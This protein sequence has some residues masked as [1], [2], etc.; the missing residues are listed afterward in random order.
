MSE[1]G[2]VA[3]EECRRKGCTGI[4]TEAERRGCSCH[5]NPPCSACT[6]DVAYCS[7]CDWHGKDDQYINDFR[8]SVN[9]ATKMFEAYELR[10]LDPNK[11][12]WHSKSHTHFSMIKEGIYPKGMTQA[13]IEKQV[14]GTFGGK[15]EY[16]NGGKFKYVAYTD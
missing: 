16:F 2:Y 13:E 5:I 1:Y 3:G 7:V 4:I 8:V 9:L 10:K 11:L 12:D 15:F 14:A 6:E